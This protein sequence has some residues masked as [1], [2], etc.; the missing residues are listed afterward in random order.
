MKTPRKRRILFTCD[1]TPGTTSSYRLRSLTRLGQEVL[2]FNFQSYVPEGRILRSLQFRLPMGPMIRRINNDLLRAVEEFRPDVVLFDRPTQFTRDTIE[3]IRR[4][5]ALTVSYNQDGP[6]GP[7]RHRGWYQFHKVFRLFDLHCLFRQA[8]VVRYSSWGLRFIKVLFSYENSV[9]FPPPPTF[10]D[11]MRTREVSYIGSPYEER[12]KFLLALAEQHQLPVSLDGTWKPVLTPEQMRKYV[13]YGPILGD[14]YRQQIWQSKI[15]LSFVTR[16]HEDDI[17]H[18]SIEIAACQSFL[19]AL[20][21][22]GH[23][24]CFEEDKEAVFFSDLEECADKCRFYLRKPELREE[25]A[26]RGRERAVRSGYDND[27][28]LARILNYI[29]GGQD[30]DSPI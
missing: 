27:T 30:G 7:L 18:K 25:I 17:S 28:Q 24:A 11:A 4:R 12:P 2:P 9:H 29:D 3:K 21:T 16:F 23:E 22:P 26:R 14:S 5:G 1:E 8:D 15:N 13:R 20:R 6:F 19:L 10:T